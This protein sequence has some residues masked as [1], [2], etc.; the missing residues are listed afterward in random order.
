MRHTTNWRRNWIPGEE[1]NGTRIGSTADQLDEGG[2]GLYSDIVDI[3]ENYIHNINSN[4]KLVEVTDVDE[5]AVADTGVT[6]HYLTL[7]SP[8]DN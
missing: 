3:N 6:E 5:L 8:Y 4:P 1:S 2:A 7:D